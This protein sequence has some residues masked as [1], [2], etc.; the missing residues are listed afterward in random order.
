MNRLVEMLYQMN[1]AVKSNRYNPF[2][3]ANQQPTPGSEG[4]V[5]N[6]Q[7]NENLMGIDAALK[8]IQNY[9]TMLRQQQA[10]QARQ[11]QPA[12]Q[13][14][15]PVQPQPDYSGNSYYFGDNITPNWQAAQYKRQADSVQPMMK[16]NFTPTS[17]LADIQMQLAGNTGITPAWQTPGPSLVDTLVKKQL[18]DELGQW[19]NLSGGITSA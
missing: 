16:P 14:Q 10:Q 4:F 18:E 15:A 19:V 8:Q 2:R 17:E 1:D 12:A 3:V 6:F 13:P 11:P 7:P 5:D 9:N